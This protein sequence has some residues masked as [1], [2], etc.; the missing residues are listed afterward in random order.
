MVLGILTNA[1][2]NFKLSVTC[3]KTT[4]VIT[5][6]GT[7]PNSR[8]FGKSDGKLHTFTM[9]GAQSTVSPDDLLWVHV[10]KET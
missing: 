6:G 1:L 10:H 5:Q 2:Y 7:C 9:L 3:G 8:V 4:K